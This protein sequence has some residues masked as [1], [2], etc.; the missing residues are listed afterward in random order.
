MGWFIRNVV[1]FLSARRFYLIAFTFIS[2]AVF[3]LYASDSKWPANKC[4]A[5]FVGKDSDTIPDPFLEKFM[6]HFSSVEEAAIA[7]ID[8]VDHEGAEGFDLAWQVARIR[9][10]ARNALFKLVG[11]HTEP[12]Q[13]LLSARLPLSLTQNSG[14][15]RTHYTWPIAPEYEAHLVGL[16]AL[17]LT[18]DSG[19]INRLVKILK[20][21]YKGSLFASE[22]EFHAGEKPR[23]YDYTLYR[24]AAAYTLSKLPVKWVQVKGFASAYLEAC[25]QLDFSSKVVNESALRFAIHNDATELLDKLVHSGKHEEFLRAVRSI[26]S[27]DPAYLEHFLRGLNG[28]FSKSYKRVLESRT[29][30][31]LIS[32]VMKTVD[33][34]LHLKQWALDQA[35]PVQSGKWADGEFERTWA[36]I[37]GLI[38]KETHPVLVEQAA[39]LI[40]DWLTWYGAGLAYDKKY[41]ISGW[42]L[43]ERRVK[44]ARWLLDLLSFPGRKF[45]KAQNIARETWIKFASS[46]THAESMSRK[47]I[48]WWV[49]EF[50]ENSER[51]ESESTE[52]QKFLKLYLNE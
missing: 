39:N 3:P 30:L 27:N 34:P 40:D 46:S 43:I 42:Q 33:Y 14:L 19:A 22:T 17:A 20:G 7:V 48:E 4:G 47:T 37:S 11:E 44:A 15:V 50:P 2:V 51:V 10:T 21:E 25:N 41:Y 12:I 28:E 9:W 23:K 49:L 52:F 29:P 38:S 16:R 18:G 24:E 13:T 6:D 8:A 36:A 32:F 31:N 1:F 5:I 35:R 26:T 45:K